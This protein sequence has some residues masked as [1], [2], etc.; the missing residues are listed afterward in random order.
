MIDCTEKLLLSDR[1]L[2]NPR[3]SNPYFKNNSVRRETYREG[4]WERVDI[5][6]D[7]E[8][9]GDGYRI[10]SDGLNFSPKTT[11]CTNGFQDDPSGATIHNVCTGAIPLICVMCHAGTACNPAFSVWATM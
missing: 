1:S 2:P 5:C 6:L 7:A 10:E 8:Y 3:T 9:H 11:T 4:D